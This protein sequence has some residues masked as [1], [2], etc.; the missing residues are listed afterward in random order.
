MRTQTYGFYLLRGRTFI[1]ELSFRGFRNYCCKKTCLYG[2]RIV[3]L[4]SLFIAWLLSV[5]FYLCM[6]GIGEYL[7]VHQ[8]LMF[9]AYGS[10]R[11][12]AN[13]IPLLRAI[14]IKRLMTKRKPE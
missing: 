9:S 7:H 12:I 13:S 2:G 6:P 5:A 4:T 3:L 1:L 14:E 10:F 11:S 8:L